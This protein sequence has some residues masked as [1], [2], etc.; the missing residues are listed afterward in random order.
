MSAH[1]EIETVRDIIEEYDNA[2]M[3]AGLSARVALEKVFPVGTEV[4]WEHGKRIRTGT[5]YGRCESDFAFRITKK[6]TNNLQWKR[7]VGL[8]IKKGATE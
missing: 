2:S 5:I 6:G 3:K 8:R 7:A 4:E 1:P